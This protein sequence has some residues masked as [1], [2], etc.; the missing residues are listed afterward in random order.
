MSVSV[1]PHLNF[2]DEARAALDFYKGVFGGEQTVFTYEQAGNV[3]TPADAG[4]VM[5]GQV[6]SDSGVRVMAYDVPSAMPY[7]PGDNAF[8]VSLRGADADEIRAYWEGLS[9]GAQILFDLAPASWSPLYG[10]IKDR[11]GVTWV[12]DVEVKYT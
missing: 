7:A 12:L 6:V 9:A 2:R 1:T 10:M 5:W 11:Y 8:F 4:Q 3:Q